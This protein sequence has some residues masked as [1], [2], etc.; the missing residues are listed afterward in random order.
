MNGAVRTREHKKFEKLNS[1]LAIITRKLAEKTSR[2]DNKIVGRKRE[3]LERQK[4]I[5]ERKAIPNLIR[6]IG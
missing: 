2:G 5:L 4:I 1:D 3:R 6:Q